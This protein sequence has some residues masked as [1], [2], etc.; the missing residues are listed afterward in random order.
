MF[1]TT[2]T[3]STRYSPTDHHSNARRLSSS[4][5][6]CEISNNN[7]SLRWVPSTCASHAASTAAGT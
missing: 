7:S 5:L 3:T 1:A 6:I 4:K 2:A